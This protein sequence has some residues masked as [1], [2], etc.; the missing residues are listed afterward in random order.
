[1]WVKCAGICRLIILLF[2]FF[3]F[4]NY[5]KGQNK[6]SI[7]SLENVLLKEIPDSSRLN[8]LFLLCQ[9]YYNNGMADRAVE[10]ALKAN[11]LSE[12][13]GLKMTAYQEYILGGVYN[14]MG[15]LEEALSRFLSSIEGL[16]ESGESKRLLDVYSSVG[17][18]Y[19]RQFDFIKELEMT[20]KALE[21]TEKMKL[22][23]DYA[24]TLFSISQIFSR[25]KDFDEEVLYL[26]KFLKIAGKYQLD[27]W[28]ADAHFRLGEINY[29]NKKYTSA[30]SDY[31]NAVKHYESFNDTSL[32]TTTLSRIA[33][34]HYLDK[35]LDNSESVYLQVLNLSEK[36]GYKN[37]ITN[38]YGNLGSI[39]R[40]QEE[41]EKALKYYDKSIELSK[42]YSDYYN[43]WWVYGD[44]SKLYLKQKNY[45]QALWYFE[46]SEKYNDIIRRDLNLDQQIE[47]RTRYIEE[48]STKE[49]KDLSQKF[50]TSKILLYGL[51]FLILMIFIIGF[52]LF[53]QTRLKTK[54]RIAAMN[55]KISEI[56]QKNLRQQMNPHFIFN[57]LNSIQYYMFGNDKMATNKYLTKFSAL[58]RQTLENSEKTSITIQEEMDA[59]ELYL[60]L[61][62]IR[63]K[64]KFD[65]KIQIDKNIDPLIHKVPTMLIQPFVEN[66]ICHGI[67]SLKSQGKII[68]DLKLSGDLI[69]C[70]IEDNGIGREKAM[71]IKQKTKNDHS[72]FGTSITEN[73]LRLINS[74]YGNDLKLKYTD[75]VD[76]DG[77]ASGT[78]V[79][80]LIPIMTRN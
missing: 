14:R 12:S 20:K 51:S 7:D 46:L 19:F 80:I 15:L 28:K 8:T 31:N 2:S 10:Y 17:K 3:F 44:M 48:K 41:I 40:D 18:I 56:T 47:A 59:L 78:K 73:R 71:E 26:E 16:K 29:I 68:V 27:K 72:S 32:L 60:E 36:A 55:H 75:L 39:Y 45:K 30:I 49:L 63:F 52:L 24:K 76:K 13:Q 77:Q 37:Y 58:M 1:M 61:E 74:I 42:S 6:I 25:L 22:G 64:K 34:M 50:K 70:T 5:S 4:I 43:L 69:I 79:E 38:T 53:R 35:D 57:T 23:I 11:G 54:Q 66:S 62:A 33:Y 9:N 67:K 65:Y 21:Y